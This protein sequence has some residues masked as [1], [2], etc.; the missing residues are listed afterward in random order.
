MTRRARFSVLRLVAVVAVLAPFVAA[1][2][3]N[4]LYPYATPGSSF[5]QT[6]PN[7]M[8]VSAETILKTHIA[9]YDKI[10]NAIFILSHQPNK[11]QQT[12]ELYNVD[13]LSVVATSTPRTAVLD[14]STKA[15]W[16]R[17]RIIA[18]SV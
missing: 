11:T 17:Q 16:Q 12:S 7:G 8:I 2:T 14:G 10:Y 15:G 6:D 4:D 5:L 1:I 3:K 18:L 9:F 13:V